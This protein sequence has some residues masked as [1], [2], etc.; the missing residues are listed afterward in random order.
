MNFTGEVSSKAASKASILLST[1]D[2][3]QEHIWGS[4]CKSL[5]AFVQCARLSC[6][7]EIITKLH[8]G[9]IIGGHIKASLWLSQFLTSTLIPNNYRMGFILLARH[10]WAQ[11][12]ESSLNHFRNI[13]LNKIVPISADGDSP[14]KNGTA[15]CLHAIFRN[16]LVV[17]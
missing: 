4:C 5:A 11:H 13:L 15:R 7:T 16:C 14:R 2:Y 10:Y 3:C 1:G 17:Y 12:Y 6:R 9:G 8:N